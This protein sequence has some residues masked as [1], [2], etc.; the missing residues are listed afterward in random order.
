M[1]ERFHINENLSSKG[2]R[3]RKKNLS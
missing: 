1:D 3:E 2:E